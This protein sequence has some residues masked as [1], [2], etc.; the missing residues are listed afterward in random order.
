MS[1][2]TS[3]KFVRHVR[4]RIVLSL[5]DLSV[6][7][8]VMALIHAI[9]AIAREWDWDLLDYSLVYGE[10]PTDPVPAG[11]LIDELWCQPLVQQ[12]QQ[13]GC[14]MVRLGRAVNVH[15]HLL[16]AVLP[17]MALAGQLAARHF[18]DRSFVHL[19]YV[20][21]NT[22][23][24]DSNSYLFYKALCACADAN[25]LIVETYDMA[26]YH[27]RDEPPAERFERRKREIGGW[28]AALPK[29]LGLLTYN[30]V[31]A[32]TLSVICRRIGLN[33]PEEVAILGVGNTTWCE[34]A[35]IELSSVM[36]N[37][38]ARA[39]EAMQLLRDLMAGKKTCPQDPVMVP[40]A[41]IKQRRSTDILAVDDLI[42]AKALRFMWEHARE[43][44]GVRDVAGEVGLSERQL[45]RRFRDSLGLSVNQELVRRRLDEVRRLLQTTTVSV[46]D[47]APM[48]G[49]R[50]TRHLHHSF[51]RATGLS[52]IQFRLQAPS[53]I[54]CKSTL[55]DQ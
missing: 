4:P 18:L 45:E 16:P 5:S 9:I 49:F 2:R 10:F 29:P 38:A 21:W 36:L 33:V 8:D 1:R 35:P 51:R 54:E 26:M 43:N 52:P 24:P 20:G 11:A 22:A 23:L 28:L 25:G 53:V 6:S 44:I 7:P 34:R 19:A 3:D 12:L 17:D 42:V 55:R 30:D 50:S 48:T 31:M 15:D 13:R 32:A 47:I 14:P 46:T 40:P 41:G 27:Q 39:R 37:E